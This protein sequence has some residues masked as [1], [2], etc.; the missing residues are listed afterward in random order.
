MPHFAPVCPAL[1]VAPKPAFDTTSRYKQ[2]SFSLARFRPPSRACAVSVNYG[3]FCAMTMRK[4]EIPNA[5]SDLA[6][7]PKKE[8][9]ISRKGPPP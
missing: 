8:P 7:G 6:R 5:V 2:L 4:S 3:S 9:K 1:H